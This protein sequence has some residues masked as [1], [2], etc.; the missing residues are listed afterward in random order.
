VLTDLLKGI[1][2]GLIVGVIFVIRSNYNRGVTF[3]KE[4]NNCLIKLR[5]NVSYLNKGYL[6]SELEKLPNGVNVLIDGSVA[7]FVDP[8]IYELI[9]DFIRTAK[10][11]QINIELKRTMT[12]QNDLFKI[13]GRKFDSE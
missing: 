7:R 10:E 3:V 5:D 6:R 13:G 8:D 11:K 2:I 1:G 12:S 4:G 9:D